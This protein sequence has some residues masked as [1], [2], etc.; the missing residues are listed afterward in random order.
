MLRHLVYACNVKVTLE[1]MRMNGNK[2][3]SV[4][5]FFF[6]NQ[7]PKTSFHGEKYDKLCQ[8]LVWIVLFTDTWSH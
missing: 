6:P 4:S 7:I 2:S 8:G 3:K 1:V 5:L